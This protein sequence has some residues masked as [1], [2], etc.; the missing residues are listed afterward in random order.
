MVLN[1]PSG[2]RSP[3]LMTMGS[4]PRAAVGL[5]VLRSGVQGPELAK[6]RIA[7][8]ARCADLLEGS[9]CTGGIVRAQLRDPEQQVGLIGVLEIALGDA[10]AD[11]RD[12]L[13]VLAVAHV[14]R[15]HLH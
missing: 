14:G 5:D 12:C 8:I 15:A 3:T 4:T 7:G 2:M 9:L 11:Q 10:L 13:V 1:L 6:P